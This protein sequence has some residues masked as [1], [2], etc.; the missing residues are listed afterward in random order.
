MKMQALRQNERETLCGTQTEAVS[1]DSE[2]VHPET[3][4]QRG[5]EII[6]TASQVSKYCSVGSGSPARTR[7]F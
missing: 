3:L 6:S 7:K 1:A 2:L 4:L 5:K